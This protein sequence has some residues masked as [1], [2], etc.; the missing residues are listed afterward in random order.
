[1]KKLVAV[2]GIILISCVCFGSLYTHPEAARSYTPAAVEQTS[3][4]GYVIRDWNGKI[5]VFISGRDKPFKVTSTQTATLPKPD[6]KKLKSGIYTE[7]KQELE[8]ILEDYC[9]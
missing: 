4:A 6:I 9:S 3:A 7:N 8:R 1:M 5:A 2:T